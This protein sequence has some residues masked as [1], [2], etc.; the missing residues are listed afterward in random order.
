M[1][2]FIR[3]D[4]KPQHQLPEEFASDDV[5]YSEDFVKFFLEQFTSEGDTI[6]DPFAGYG[7]TMLVAESMDRIAYGI[8][9]D[10]DRYS[11]VRPLLKHPSRLIHGDSLKLS[12]Y[13]LPNFDFSLTSPPY[14]GEDDQENPFAAY[15]KPGQGYAH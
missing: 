8:E 11:Y 9:Y 13:D 2:T 4:H 1:K 14:M 7:T 3:L 5:R 10:E 12:S 6:L 15:S